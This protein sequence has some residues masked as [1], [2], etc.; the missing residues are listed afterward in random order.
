MDEKKQILVILG[1][2]AVIAIMAFAAEIIK[3]ITG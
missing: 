3:T 1:I 2:H